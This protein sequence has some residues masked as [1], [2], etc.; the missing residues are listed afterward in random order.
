MKNNFFKQNTFEA[1]FYSNKTTNRENTS[2]LNKR[3][4]IN[5]INNKSTQNN[6]ISNN[7]KS[8]IEPYKNRN[9]CNNKT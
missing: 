3:L 6:M 1:H 5:K 7:K 8:N 9:V 2:L 4:K